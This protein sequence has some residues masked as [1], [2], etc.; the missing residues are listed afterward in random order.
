[1]MMIFN[2]D[3]VNQSDI[4]KKEKIKK[5]RLKKKSNSK[6]IEIFSTKSVQSKMIKFV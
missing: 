1:M 6:K 3:F 2:S 4:I 5:E